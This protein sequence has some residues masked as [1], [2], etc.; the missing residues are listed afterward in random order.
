MPGSKNSALMKGAESIVR[1]CRL[2]GKAAVEKIRVKKRYRDQSLDLRLRETRTRLEVRLLSHARQ[3]GVPCPKVLRWGSFN[4]IMER[5]KCSMLHQLIGRGKTPKKGLEGLFFKSGS[6]LATI[7]KSGIVHG[8]YTPANI[9]VM[10]D[11]SAWVIDFGLGKFSGRD[12]D[13]ATDV[14]T[15]LKATGNLKARDNKLSTSFISGYL[16]VQPAGRR[17]IGTA[18][19]KKAASNESIVSLAYQIDARSRYSQRTG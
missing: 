5:L 12:E 4:I 10:E 15:F 17:G 16:A 19:Q 18:S 11:D 13:R 9:A 2:E 1:A 14:L 8:D 6:L 7:H 3:S